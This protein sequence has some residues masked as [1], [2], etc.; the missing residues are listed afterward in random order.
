MA[1]APSVMQTKGPAQMIPDGIPEASS[2]S[3]NEIDDQRREVNFIAPP[4][5][6]N[7][8]ER[9]KL[10]RALNILDTEREDRFSSITRLLCS[11]FD[12]PIAAVSLVDADK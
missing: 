3:T 12:V 10:L 11:V 7:E 9:V 4:K 2:S 6:V 5:T 1:I 8:E